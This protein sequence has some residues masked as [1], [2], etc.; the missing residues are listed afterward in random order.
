MPFR[1][2][3]VDYSLLAL[4]EN[5][6]PDPA[7][8]GVFIADEKFSLSY[9]LVK[10]ISAI[11]GIEALKLVSFYEASLDELLAS[12]ELLSSSSEL[13]SISASTFLSI[14]K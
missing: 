7:G 10:F 3:E 11:S 12:E 4:G 1:F 13:V 8:P 2:L 6:V 14:L 9:F 5:S